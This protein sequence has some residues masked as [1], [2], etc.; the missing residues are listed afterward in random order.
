MTGA[1]PPVIHV[2]T[3]VPL[4]SDKTGKLITEA[5]WGL[6]YKPDFHFNGIQ[7]GAMPDCQVDTPVDQW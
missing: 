7:G 6:C 3:D 1:M 4:R 5:L 2:D